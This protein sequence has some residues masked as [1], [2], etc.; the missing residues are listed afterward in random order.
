MIRRGAGGESSLCVV[1][2]KSIQ[3]DSCISCRRG[4][5]RLRH[6]IRLS[7]AVGMRRPHLSSW[8]CRRGVRAPNMLAP[9][10]EL[11]PPGARWPAEAAPMARRITSLTCDLMCGTRV[12]A[13]GCLMRRKA[14]GRR[15][16]SAG[17][18]R[19]GMSDE[20]TK[21]RR[22][23]PGL[24]LPLSSAGAHPRRRRRRRRWRRPW[25]HLLPPSFPAHPPPT[26][27]PPS[28]PLC[29]PPMAKSERREI[30]Q[31]RRWSALAKIRYALQRLNQH[32]Y[33]C[34][35][36]TARRRS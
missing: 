5:A 11:G 18:D 29:R 12:R 23:F 14:S 27:P 26:H 25:L 35:N 2:A 8:S 28:P 36:H 31:S 33:G 21:G 22:S 19:D 24:R 20:R 7:S 17:T 10:C 9:S 30:S 34:T 13:C 1:P 4:T 3:T 32:A 6:V 16:D 15:S